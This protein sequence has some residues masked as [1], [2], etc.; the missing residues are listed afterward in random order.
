MI[1]SLAH[2][3]A[4]SATGKNCYQAPY[5]ILDKRTLSWYDKIFNPGV[6]ARDRPTAQHQ[7]IQLCNMAELAQVNYYS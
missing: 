5:T 3:A 6:F 2:S 4:Q 7:N 1:Q